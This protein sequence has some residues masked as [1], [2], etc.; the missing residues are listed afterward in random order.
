MK[1]SV[2]ADSVFFITVDVH[3]EFLLGDTDEFDDD[4]NQCLIP[5]RRSSS[6]ITPT[7]TINQS[8]N[9]GLMERAVSS[10]HTSPQQ[11]LNSNSGSVNKTQEN[12][13]T[14]PPNGSGY[15][16]AFKEVALSVELQGSFKKIDE[17]SVTASAQK[18]A[19]PN[20]NVAS[21]AKAKPNHYVAPSELG[22][23][24][25]NPQK[26]GATTNG[27][28]HCSQQCITQEKLKMQVIS[29]KL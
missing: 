27:M 22:F 11:P 18:N 14:T 7:S 16:E 26:S 23:N 12:Q 25:H 19:A 9:K 4:E 3:L 1:K 10:A 21:H 2:N 8:R 20:H 24:R 29:L 5:R 15:K 6:H 13:Y 17:S 28:V